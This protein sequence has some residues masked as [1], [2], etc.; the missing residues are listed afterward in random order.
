MKNLIAIIIALITVN[1]YLIGQSTIGFAMGLNYSDVY[2]GK[3]IDSYYSGGKYNSYNSFAFEI[4]YLKRHE[5]L[6]NY[7]MSFSYISRKFGMNSSYSMHNY[8]RNIDAQFKLAYIS[9]A[10]LPEIAYG[11]K[12][13]F[14]F[15]LGPCIDLFVNG[16][17]S[18]SNYSGIV[19]SSSTSGVSVSE[20]DYK[21]SDIFNKFLIGFKSGI[22]FDY[23]LAGK[24]IFQ[25]KTNLNTVFNNFVSGENLNYVSVHCRNVSLLAGVC[26]IF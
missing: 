7:R 9:F 10:F 6:I 19:N 8:E 5:R 12:L 22:G 26:Y 20:T 4:D 1:E 2:D 21:A 23:P 25:F 17:Q 13:K 14:I 18:G 11:K 24:I 3:N 16:S 15:N